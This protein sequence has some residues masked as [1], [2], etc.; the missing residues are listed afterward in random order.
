MTGR[1]AQNGPS[2]PTSPRLAPFI[3]LVVIIAAVFIVFAP[4]TTFFFAQDD[5]IL[6]NDAA[7]NG[8]GTV[9]SHFAP[10]PGQFRPLSKGLYFLVMYHLFGMNAAPYHWLSLVLHALNV[11]LLYFLLRQLS[12]RQA[13]ALIVTCVFAL[14]NAFFHVVAWISCDQQLLAL[15]FMLVS[16]VEGIRM[17]N[18]GG[19]APALVSASA[20]ALALAC[21]EQVYAV[22]FLLLIYAGTLQ[23]RGNRR[24]RFRSASRR[25]VPHFI[26]LAGYV[27]LM[28]GWK[29]LPDAGPYVLHAG[30]NVF[31]NLW[32][33][34][35]WTLEVGAPTRFAPVLDTPPL[36]VGHVAFILIVLYLVLNR[37]F[38]SLLFGVG[39]FLAS[40]LPVLF[41][42]NH[43]FYL[44]TYIPSC[45]AFYL[46]AVV[47]EQLATTRLL[48]RPRAMAMLVL[49][50]IAV[51]SSYAFVRTRQ[52]IERYATP[53]YPLLESFVL[54]RAVIA[55]NTWND[56]SAKESDRA[57]V[58]SV[59]MVFKSNKDTWLND[60]VEAAL[61][62]GALIQLF[63]GKPHMRV[64]FHLM[65]DTLELHSD[66]MA[67]TRIFLYDLIGHCVPAA[68]YMQRGP[69]EENP[70][71]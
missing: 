4:L 3:A 8:W 65:S 62:Y 53:D 54:R 61:G 59:H 28:L 5:F 52:N 71:H 21:M 63:Y 19:L 26:I 39:F 23:T 17:L 24:R 15:A 66:Q 22:P 9:L 2:L 43:A 67:R 1:V 47:L 60:N 14:S 7:A 42:Q 31:G 38:R 57:N 51:M 36:T 33:Y 40:I 32:T 68:D 13:P 48:R 49:L 16:L 6:L 11:L 25:L 35:G 58:D 56:L 34:L 18:R 10:D 12:I 37:Q 30:T 46:G 50:T 45:G 55:R 41:L 20:Y 70:P 27:A 69:A 64:D 29:H 44:H